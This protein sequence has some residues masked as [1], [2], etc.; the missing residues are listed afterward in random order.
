MKPHTREQIIRKS[1]KADELR[2]SGMTVLDVC[3]Q[4]EVAVAAYHQWRKKYRD[5]DIEK[6]T[7]PS[8]IDVCRSP[9]PILHLIVLRAH[10]R[11]EQGTSLLIFFRSAARSVISKLRAVA[12][13]PVKSA[14]EGFFTIVV[15]SSRM[16]SHVRWNCVSACPIQSKL[17]LIPEIVQ[18]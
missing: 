2:V 12:D 17:K 15:A 6:F 14:P 11:F 5:M 4:L 13:I 16:I 18:V 7:K 1:Q 9:S 10:V 3:R 8:Q